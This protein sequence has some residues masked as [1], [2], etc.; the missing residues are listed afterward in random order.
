MVRCSWVLHR[1][2]AGD[3]IQTASGIH[4]LWEL[5][6]TLSSPLPIWPSYAETFCGSISEAAGRLLG[7]CDGF[8]RRRSIHRNVGMALSDDLPC[9]HCGGIL[10]TAGFRRVGVRTRRHC[11]HGTRV[12]GRQRPLLRSHGCGRLAGA[13][14]SLAS[15]GSPC[16]CNSR[17][18]QR[19]PS[20]VGHRP[21]RRLLTRSCIWRLALAPAGD[22]HPGSRETSPR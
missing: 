15:L 20:H 6:E 7:S 2:P 14:A 13:Q 5:R 1:N 3:I 22:R 16:P 17:R 21:F 18:H 9:P 11:F 12:S 19:A 4:R 8:F 10:G